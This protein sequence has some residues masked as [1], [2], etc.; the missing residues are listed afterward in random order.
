MAY[1]L[2]NQKACFEAWIFLK[3]DLKQKETTFK[4]KFVQV[5]THF[6]LSHSLFLP[7]LVKKIEHQKEN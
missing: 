6:F 1:L 3:S 2:S 4:V 7:E 5:S